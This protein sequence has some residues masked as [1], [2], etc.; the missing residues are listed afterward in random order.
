MTS[1]S[2]SAA[3]EGSDRNNV[4]PFQCFHSQD[5][6]NHTDNYLTSYGASAPPYAYSLTDG[7]CEIHKN[8]TNV[9]YQPP[10]CRPI[11]AGSD[12]RLGVDDTSTSMYA[13]RSS[14]AADASIS[15]ES[16]PAMNQQSSNTD[17]AIGE[18]MPT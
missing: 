5:T 13:L 17:S 8:P 12:V 7:R 14:V 2:Q 16:H 3:L 4:T 1:P 10:V 9:A 6:E 18:S 11:D 15:I